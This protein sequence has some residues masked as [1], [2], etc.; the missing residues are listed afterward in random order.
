M[1]GAVARTLPFFIASCHRLYGTQPEIAGHQSQFIRYSLYVLGY[2]R[3]YPKN[4]PSSD[5]PRGQM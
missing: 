5:V 1:F 3:A 2:P 4:Q